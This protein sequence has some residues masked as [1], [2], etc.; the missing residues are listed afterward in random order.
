M[1]AISFSLP[2]FLRS[3]VDGIISFVSFISHTLSIL[4]VTHTRKT[5]HPLFSALEHSLR[6]VPRLFHSTHVPLH[7]IFVLACGFT[8]INFWH[9]PHKSHRHSILTAPSTLLIPLVAFDHHVINIW[10]CLYV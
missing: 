8:T 10:L 1:W 9:F 5:T 2:I 4:K 7:Q 3:Q 6:E